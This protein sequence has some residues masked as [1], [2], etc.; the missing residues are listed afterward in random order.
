VG[1]HEQ[2]LIDSIIGEDPLTR[3]VWR[4]NGGEWADK[5]APT[6]LKL[7]AKLADSLP[8]VIVVGTGESRFNICH[9][10]MVKAKTT[11]SDQTIDTW[12]LSKS[13]EARLLWGRNAIKA[14]LRNGE[15]ARK[16]HDN[17]SLTYVGHSPIYSDEI[18]QRGSMI[19]IDT[20]GVTNHK[21]RDPNYALTMVDVYT[22]Q[23]Y[24]A[25]RL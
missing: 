18:H 4:D 20:G 13:D 21:H 1:N 2:F 24:Q 12:N 6:R 15:L 17:L 19:Y 22:G 23:C 7:L 25:Q 8:L 5:V 11:F 10:E 9:A 16:I 3:S 14:E